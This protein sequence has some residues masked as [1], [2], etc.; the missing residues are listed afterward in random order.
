MDDDESASAVDLVEVDAAPDTDEHTAS[1][2]GQDTAITSFLR[3]ESPDARRRESTWTRLVAMAGY[4]TRDGLRGLRRR[5]G[6]A[7]SAILT[8]SLCALLAGGAA[9]ARAGVDATM[10]RWADG[11]EFVVYL[12][13]GAA[14]S[15]VARVHDELTNAEGVRRVTRVTQEAAYEEYRQLYS[16]DPTMTDAVTADLLPS[17]FRVAPVD[18]DPG[19]IRRITGP[20]ASD[21]AVYQVVTADQAVRD[22]RDL[23]GAVSGFGTALAVV[24]GLVGVVLSATMI[25]SSISSRQKEIDMMRSVGAGRTYIAAPVAIE[26]VVIGLVAAAVAAAVLSTAVVR[27]GSSDS[28]VVA[29][30]LPSAA[31]ARTVIV[32]VGLITVAVCTAV[33]VITTA[34]ALR[35]AR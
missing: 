34:A 14:P 27:A 19:L 21:P 3:G 35:R 23:S 22:V 20:L 7:A 26:G 28:S 4:A 18:A 25:R 17:S 13:P 32:V 9:I 12:Q 29:S 1:G 2:F 10:S 16:G 5:P 31:Q 33:S 6:L 8:V 11:V 30:L 15:D 24:L